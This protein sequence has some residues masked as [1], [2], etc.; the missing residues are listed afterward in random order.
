MAMLEEPVFLPP[1]QR[2]AP[3]AA[4]CAVLPPSLVPK[5][6]GDRVKTDQR[7]ALKLAQLPLW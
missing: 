6:P 3:F 5:K 1:R 4:Q 7:D 2:S